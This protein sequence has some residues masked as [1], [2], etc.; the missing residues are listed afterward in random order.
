MNALKILAGAAILAP[1]IGTQASATITTFAAVSAFNV[2]YANNG[3]G[4]SAASNRSNGF[5][6]TFYTTSGTP[7]AI[8]DNA[9]PAAAA[10]QFSFLNNALTSFVTN[11]PA[12]LTLN[13]SATNSPAQSFA[14]FK[15]QTVF[16]GTFSILS[17]D[18]IVLGSNIFASGA[19]L[20]SGTFSLGSIVG[21]SNATSG[22]LSASTNSAAIIS[23]S[24]DFLN[25]NQAIS[26]DLS[27]GI[28]GIVSNLAN[29]NQG[30][31]NDTGRALRSF[32]AT[33]TGSFS[34]DP[35]PL[36]VPG[37]VPEPQVWAMMI[38]GFGL[39]GLQIRRNARQKAIAA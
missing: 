13:A 1:T 14:G 23:Y 25:F 9:V 8:P 15:F 32:K 3:T 36:L 19:N 18:Q 28:T 16:N 33:S 12:F 29:V 24:S 21:Q 20:L 11:V 30:L 37:L 34:S 2:V 38:G 27:L 4:G 6:G 26:R 35:A 7:P 5:G 31:N 17:A 10:V 22:S 39:V